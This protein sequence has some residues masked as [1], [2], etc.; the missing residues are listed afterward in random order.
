MSYT[1]ITKPNTPSYSNIT[2]RDASYKVTIDEL[3]NYA[4]T[5]DSLSSWKATIDD[6]NTVINI[7]TN[8][9]KPTL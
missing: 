3:T 5:I 8:I 6:M 1:Q 2:M 9:T 4:T 7:Y